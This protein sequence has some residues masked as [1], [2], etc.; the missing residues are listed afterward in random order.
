[1]NFKNNYNYILKNEV[2]ISIYD[3]LRKL[4]KEFGE[5]EYNSPSLERTTYE[6]KIFHMSNQNNIQ[7]EIEAFG[8]I[9]DE[10][11]HDL[12]SSIKKRKEKLFKIQEYTRNRI[13]IDN[14]IYI[15]DDRGVGN[16]I[17]FHTDDRKL[18]LGAFLKYY[19]IENRIP[20][21][22]VNLRRHREKEEHFDDSVY[23]DGVFTRE[24]V[25]KL[26]KYYV[27]EKKLD[28]RTVNVKKEDGLRDLKLEILMSI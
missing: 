16:S 14:E 12:L 8:Y 27:I 2:D 24:Q 11:Y 25:D 26:I 22:E 1:M 10:L 5:E 28:L 21:Y 23:L 20:M 15:K 4:I 19:S 9:E 6:E 7:K 3:K 17:W 13:I 18:T